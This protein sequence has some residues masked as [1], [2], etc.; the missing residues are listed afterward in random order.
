MFLW[1]CHPYYWSWNNLSSPNQS[2]LQIQDGHE[3]N[4]DVLKIMPQLSEVSSREMFW[5]KVPFHWHQYYSSAHHCWLMMCRGFFC[6]G[7]HICFILFLKNWS[8]WCGRNLFH[9]LAK[10]KIPFFVSCFPVVSQAKSFICNWDPY[11]RWLLQEN[12]FSI[13]SFGFQLHITL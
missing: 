13:V 6:F 11:R 1:I 4:L 12:I 3:A 7:F 9:C 2:H 8:F 10:G 5:A